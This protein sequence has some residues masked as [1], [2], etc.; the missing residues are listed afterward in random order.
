MR[1]V[2]VNG[3]VYEY[4]DLP[5]GS[6]VGRVQR[7][8]D[9]ASG[10]VPSVRIS[11]KTGKPKRTRKPK[12]PTLPKGAVFKEKPFA[13]IWCELLKVTPVQLQQAVSAGVPFTAADPQNPTP[14]EVTEVKEMIR[15]NGEYVR[16]NDAMEKFKALVDEYVM[17]EQREEVMKLLKQYVIPS[18]WGLIRLALKNN[19][20]ELAQKEMTQAEVAFIYGI[21]RSAV[22]MIEE[23]ALEKIKAKLGFNVPQSGDN[24]KMSIQEEQQRMPGQEEIGG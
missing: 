21:T 7:R 11:V 12:D 6:Q 15:L 23:R 18:D 19:P 14:E 4:P 5:L 2:K 1:I 24:Y 20:R 9:I 17:E 13:K 16:H 3:K 22:G 10:L 8:R